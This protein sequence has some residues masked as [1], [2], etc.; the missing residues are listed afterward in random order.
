MLCF[1]IVPKGFQSETVIVAKTPNGS[2]GIVEKLK[3]GGF[4][5][6]FGYAW[7]KDVKIRIGNFPQHT[8]N[9]VKSLIKKMK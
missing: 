1:E 9:D 8:L 3:K 2:K 7:E 4:L 6:A 5:V